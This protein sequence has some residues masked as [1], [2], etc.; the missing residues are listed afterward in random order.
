MHELKERAEQRATIRA[1]CRHDALIVIGTGFGD[2]QTLPVMGR[3]VYGAWASI[4]FHHTPKLAML[5]PVTGFTTIS[6]A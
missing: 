5:T 2:I 6:S 1:A 3:P 4:W